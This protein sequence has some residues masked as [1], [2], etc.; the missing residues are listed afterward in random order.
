VNTILALLVL[1]AL[2]LIWPMRWLWLFPLAV[3]I[4]A[5]LAQWP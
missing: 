3:I 4:A 5:A 1:V 2:G